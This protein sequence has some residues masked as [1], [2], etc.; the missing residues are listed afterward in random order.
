MRFCG[1]IDGPHSCNRVS[2]AVKRFGGVMVM[3]NGDGCS[4]K[5]NILLVV[6]KF[7]Q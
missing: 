1:D 3:I 6:A 7:S 4:G 2:V 5:C